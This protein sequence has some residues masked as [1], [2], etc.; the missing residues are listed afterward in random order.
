MVH[1]LDLNEFFWIH[2]AH[3]MDH[4]WNAYCPELNPGAGG[5]VAKRTERQFANQTRLTL[6]DKK[7]DQTAEA[8]KYLGETQRIDRKRDHRRIGNPLRSDTRSSIKQ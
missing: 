4:G 7:D 1:P 6:H 8:K 3:S 2:T 5:S